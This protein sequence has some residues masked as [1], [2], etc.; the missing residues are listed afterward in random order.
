MGWMH[1][2]RKLSN[3]QV[4]NQEDMSKLLAKTGRKPETHKFYE[5]LT[6]TISIMSCLRLPEG[7]GLSPP[8]TGLF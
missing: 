6:Y 8:P 7:S 5:S 1:K 2:T 3:G 4:R